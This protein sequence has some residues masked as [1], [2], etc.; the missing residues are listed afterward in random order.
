M[1]MCYITT[2][3]NFGDVTPTSP[4]SSVSCCGWGGLTNKSLQEKN[5]LFF[6]GGG[7]FWFG[8]IFFVVF[9]PVLFFCG[10]KNPRPVI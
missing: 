1:W 7:F 3:A 4:T 8:F 9:L 5:I 2:D 10:S 6:W